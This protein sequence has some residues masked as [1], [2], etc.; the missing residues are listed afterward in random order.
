MQ[1]ISQEFTAP[2]ISPKSNLAMLKEEPFLSMV[3]ARGTLMDQGAF[4]KNPIVFPE[5]KL[6]NLPSNNPR[7]SSLSI[8]PQPND[9]IKI[10]V[11]LHEP[12][13]KSFSELSKAP[14]N[15]EIRVPRAHY[16]QVPKSLLVST[17]L[18]DREAD[19]K[20]NLGD[21][22][23]E[24]SKFSPNVDYYNVHGNV[25]MVYD[26]ILRLGYDHELMEL[27]YNDRVE[28]FKKYIKESKVGDMKF[29]FFIT[30]VGES[31]VLSNATIPPRILMAFSQILWVAK[32]INNQ[33]STNF[34][35]AE[36]VQNSMRIRQHQSSVFNSL[37]VGQY[38]FY[39]RPKEISDLERPSNKF[40]SD[41]VQRTGNE[42]DL[43]SAF[44]TVP[45]AISLLE[46]E[47]KEEVQ[48]LVLKCNDKR[49]QLK[50][51]FET[52]IDKIKNSQLQIDYILDEKSKIIDCWKSL[53]KVLKTCSVLESY[54]L[55]Q[56]DKD[57]A[58]KDAKIDEH[59]ITAI[60][61]NQIIELQKMSS[62]IDVAL[63]NKSSVLLK[64]DS[65]YSKHLKS[66]FILENDDAREIKSLHNPVD[67]EV[68]N[69]N[70]VSTSRKVHRLR[71]VRLVQRTSGSYYLMT[72]IM[73][74]ISISQAFAG[75]IKDDKYSDIYCV[76]NSTF[77]YNTTNIPYKACNESLGQIPYFTCQAYLLSNGTVVADVKSAKSVDTVVYNDLLGSGIWCTINGAPKEDYN[78]KCSKDCFEYNLNL[79]VF[80]TCGG[81][82]QYCL[83]HKC[84]N[85]LTPSCK[86]YGADIVRYYQVCF[87]R[88]GYECLNSTYTNYT[89]GYLE[90][91]LTKFATQVPKRE[92]IVTIQKRI[93]SYF[94]NASHGAESNC[95]LSEDDEENRT[96]V[97]EGLW[98][99]DNILQT[100]SLKENLLN[101][102]F[103]PKGCNIDGNTETQLFCPYNTYEFN[104]TGG[105]SHLNNH[106]IYC[107]LNAP[108]GVT[109]NPC[110]DYEDH[111]TW[112]G[113]S[114]IFFS[115]STNNV[116]I[117][118]LTNCSNNAEIWMNQT[119]KLDEITS[120]G[121]YLASTI[122]S[123][124][125]VVN[126]TVS[127]H[128]HA[129]RGYKMIYLD[130]TTFVKK[131]KRNWI[132]YTGGRQLLS[133]DNSYVTI[134]YRKPNVIISSKEYP[135]IAILTKE[136]WNITIRSDDSFFS[137]ELPKEVI[138]VTGVLD[139]IF[140]SNNLMF[141]RSIVILGS[142]NCD[143]WDAINFW[144]DKA[145]DNFWCFDWQLRILMILYWTSP[146]WIIVV[147]TVIIIERRYRKDKEAEIIGFIDGKPI[148][149]ETK[150]KKV[151]RPAW[152]IA[153][154]CPC[155]MF[156]ALLDVF[157]S[158]CV[159][160]F[161]SS[162]VYSKFKERQGI[163]DATNPFDK[164]E[165]KVITD[166]SNL[167][168]SNGKWVLNSTQIIYYTIMFCLLLPLALADTCN[169]GNLVNANLKNCIIDTE[170]GSGLVCETCF[171][172][173]NY[174]LTLPTLNSESCL[175]LTD[176]NG[177]IIY[178][179]SIEYYSLRE[180]Y[181]FNRVY[182][183]SAW[184]LV[185]QSSFHC[186][187]PEWLGGKYCYADA[188]ANYSKENDREGKGLIT[189]VDAKYRPGKSDCAIV[190]N[191]P[192]EVCAF[193]GGCTYGGVGVV[194][195][196][197]IYSVNRPHSSVLIPQVKFT[198]KNNIDPDKV[199][200]LDVLDGGSEING[201]F[202]E[203]LGSLE[204][205]RV[206][207]GN[208][209]AIVNTDNNDTWLQV[210]S[211]LNAPK[212]GDIGDLQSNSRELMYSHL[213]AAF[214]FDL[215]SIQLKMRGV[216][217][218]FEG[219]PV[220]IGNLDPLFQF[221]MTLGSN[222]WSR[223]VNGQIHAL[224]MNA[225]PILINIR[226]LP[227]FTVSVKRNK[228]CP[229][230]KLESVT[231]CYAC[232]FG[233]KA[234]F[235]ARST[236]SDGLVRV[237]AS[238]DTVEIWSKSVKITR[239]ETE[240]I[241]SF[242]TENKFNDF[243]ICFSAATSV[244][245]KISYIADDVDFVQPPA[246]PANSTHED[247]DKDNE[248]TSFWKRFG[249][250]LFFAGSWVD[251]IIAVVIWIVIIAIITLGAIAAKNL[252]T[253]YRAYQVKNK[254]LKQATA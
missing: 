151:K 205:E 154:C 219:S 70:L 231:G 19:T 139:V 84:S 116:V 86:C 146:L 89:C 2:A 148:F 49:F 234:V 77:L 128:Y 110:I 38:G 173:V 61:T 74:F 99:N 150:T 14:A 113:C 18:T 175:T 238:S 6:Y 41:F 218:N 153:I 195:F 233:S 55:N 66:K 212:A 85:V 65:T 107:N 97:F 228:V 149:K 127:S 121:S 220:G 177:T 180:D 213:W 73:I 88:S 161:T 43:T 152:C 21:L 31:E 169:S 102:D 103:S 79:T 142:N 111:L 199:F 134:D 133:N 63:V 162:K 93:D 10:E 118:R 76:Q 189:N 52:L 174:Q 185:S 223:D 157:L 248:I 33:L 166:G 34:L 246:P 184:E 159:T 101:L 171:S 81:S 209:H 242:N 254:I 96:C 252:F 98:S 92:N 124:F 201:I 200:F 250:I 54:L 194:P 135:F 144:D 29:L 190:D 106:T 197:P 214:R 83:T 108:V 123:T 13:S 249:D 204:N 191:P 186:Y 182:Y 59:I 240:V 226:T 100:W 44:K 203:V 137:Q 35:S 143:I 129:S 95:T 48:D 60:E 136:A 115:E 45:A 62:E 206:H 132:T 155:L 69:E 235:R 251:D 167:V 176:D 125:S 192:G 221:P 26:L 114:K 208:L 224:R 193:G 141:N 237:T 178:E 156:A 75:H 11:S 164:K 104:A 230:M 126:V 181:F 57:N 56:T 165:L 187:C 30:V 117:T 227:G 163:E 247:L 94:Y 5:K 8:T 91:L 210:A 50:R 253:M 183:T 68:L 140:K 160:T 122:D 225:A 78:E 15:K 3:S 138:K 130:P 71:Q 58:E 90:P 239:D 147:I 222:V 80:S 39:N 36:D 40:R 51:S 241:I 16:H 170:C 12:M 211:N 64:D 229:D 232:Q 20:Y 46:F 72:A 145:W 87:D 119:V 47:G 27:E 9:F 53:L 202:V 179:I 25:V 105:Y 23:T 216:S 4:A 1:P 22:F 120:T 109:T 82:N 17:I 42:I 207:L 37:K 32:R 217:M 196:G 215:Q 198:V 243:D 236:C 244:C 245:K 172:E 188:C 158:W 131:V 24:E 168:Y 67:T 112:T 28:F 7:V